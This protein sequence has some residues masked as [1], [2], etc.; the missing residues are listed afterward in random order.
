MRKI[1]Y[2][3]GTRADFG[4]MKNSLQAIDRDDDL[5]LEVIVTGM[6]LLNEYGDTYQEI[7]DLGLNIIGKVKVSLSGES[8][9]QMSIA[10][11]NQIIG[12]TK[13]LE[14][15]KP[16][17]V[18]LLGDRG[19]MLAGAIVSLHL[20]IP[21]VHIHGGELSGT[22][23]ESVRHA[24]S[25]LS[26]YHFTATKLSKERLIKMGEVESNIF[27]IGAPG[28]DEIYNTQLIQREA[29]LEKY[30]IDSKSPFILFLF[31]PV[32]QQYKSV[33]EQLIT[34]LDGLLF[35]NTQILAIMPNS[36]AGGGIISSVLS[37]YKEQK[38]IKTVVHIARLEFLSL[39]SEADLLVGNSSSGII[40]AAS[41]GA[42]V[43]NIG[44]RQNL[45]ERNDNVVDVEI[46]KSQI[47]NGINRARSLNKY[48][49]GNVYGDG[50]SS[51]RIVELLKSLA[52]DS[53]IL[54]KVN[55]Y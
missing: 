28:L 46:E 29:L 22:V 44:D 8:G 19:E 30:D 53:K 51:Q 34:I 25:K 45:R 33:K 17:L 10:L 41:L 6:H 14:K 7:L 9:S 39:L 55:A 15:D 26:H 50:K 4:L 20:N 32:V 54:D 24:I 47:I 48:S 42:P 38:K 43:I 13:I 49:F 23:D 3:S 18:L 37:Q 52:I 2:I 40:E 11:G 27:T 36:D 12:F 31:H 16:D 35:D 5:D 1:C 21:I